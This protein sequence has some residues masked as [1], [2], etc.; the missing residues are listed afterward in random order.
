MVKAGQGKRISE[1]KRLI[2]EQVE[3]KMKSLAC[4]LLVVGGLRPEAEN[5]RSELANLGEFL[6][7]QLPRI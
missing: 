2:V 4:L 5:I 1:S 6:S 7:A 3:R